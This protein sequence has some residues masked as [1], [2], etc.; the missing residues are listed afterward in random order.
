MV[1]YTLVD[2]W[3]KH[4]QTGFTIVELLI[5][6][7]VIAI[8][9][10]ITIVAFNGIQNRANDSAV[11][12]DLANIAKQLEATKAVSANTTYPTTTELTNGTK[13]SASKGAYDT[14]RNNFYYC[15]TVDNLNYAVG[16]VS[17]SGSQYFLVNGKIRDATTTVWGSTTCNE[18]STIGTPDANAGTGFSTANVVPGSP[19]LTSNIT[20]YKI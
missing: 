19:G 2:M 7:V 14:S 15:R 5:V 12:S 9:A 13:L 18:L 4:K 8:L 16:V 20:L 17:K 10:A 1:C 11:K 6:I 3:A